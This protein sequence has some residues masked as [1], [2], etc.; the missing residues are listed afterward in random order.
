MLASIRRLW[1]H[2]GKKLK[3]LGVV[4]VPTVPGRPNLDLDRPEKPRE[5]EGRFPNFRKGLSKFC[6][7]CTL[8]P[9]GAYTYGMTPKVRVWPPLKTTPGAEKGRNLESNGRHSLF[10]PKPDQRAP[11]WTISGL[12]FR[13]CANAVLTCV[14]IEKIKAL[15]FLTCVRKKSKL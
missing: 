1:G 6:P 7:K 13:I 3:V 10:A 12:H 9:L 8:S 2:P 5:A 15:I 14:S 11:Q 4:T